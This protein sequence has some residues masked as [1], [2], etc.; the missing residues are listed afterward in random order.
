MVLGTRKV[1]VQVKKSGDGEMAIKREVEWGRVVPLG[2]RK[3]SQSTRAAV[4]VSLRWRQRRGTLPSSRTWAL[5]LVAGVVG[6]D[7]I[8]FVNALSLSYHFLL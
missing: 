4:A 6:K 8:I 5:M 7:K 1:R 2:G 3:F